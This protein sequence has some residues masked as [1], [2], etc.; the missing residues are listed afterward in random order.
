VFTRRRQRSAVCSVAPALLAVVLAWAGPAEAQLTLDAAEARV[1]E[2]FFTRTTFEIASTKTFYVAINEP[3]ASNSNNGRYPTYQGGTNGPFK[4]FNSIALLSALANSGSS[5]VAVFVRAGRYR[6]PNG[7][8]RIRGGG[9]ELRP[10]I[11]A[12]Y[13]GDTRPVIDGEECLPWDTIHAIAEGQT[14]YT[15]RVPSLIRMD[16]RYVIVQDLQLQ[17]GFAHVVLARGQHMILRRNVIRG[18]YE[19]AIKT[20]TGADRGL[21][22]ENDIAG[23]V[24]Q[25]VDHFG[26]TNWLITRNVMH[27]PAPDPLS[28]G[29]GGNAITVKGSA[30]NTV[31]TRN[32]IRGFATAVDQSAVTFGAP[33]ALEFLRYDGVGNPMASALD[34]VAMANTVEQFTGAA[35]GIQSCQNCIIAENQVQ[36]TIGAV[37]I[38]IDAEVRA[39]SYESGVFPY[40]SGTVVRGNRITFQTVNCE[41]P[42]TLG[43]SCFALFVANT[44]EAADLVAS[45]NIYYSPEMPPFVWNWE[46]FDL[47]S[48]Q[49]ITGTEISSQLLPLP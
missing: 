32:T 38:G 20:T 22:S 6:A 49:L 44:L 7:G 21:V 17:C 33:A 29:V 4:D 42:V 2:P 26:A 11:L 16:G 34:G 15:P 46:V 14:S 48:F 3:G 18:A 45:D 24:S 30:I 12:G 37:K 31:I 39:A 28:G 10:A 1:M 35:F 13:P 41:T 47:S 40:S 43:Q 27:D 19:D 36:T 25:G 5:G 9:S 23:F 8:V